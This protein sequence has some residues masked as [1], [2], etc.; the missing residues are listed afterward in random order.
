MTFSRAF[1]FREF[2]KRNWVPAKTDI[3][4]VYCIVGFALRSRLFIVV[5]AFDELARPSD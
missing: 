1:N 2:C 5:N 4:W 3:F